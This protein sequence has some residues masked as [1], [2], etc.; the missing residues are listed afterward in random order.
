M[1]LVIFTD[2]DGTLLDHD[3]YDWRPAAPMIARLRDQG[4]PLVFVTSKTRAEVAVLRAEMGVDEP[5]IVENGAA[6]FFPERYGRLDLPEAVPIGAFRAL[7]FGRP[8]TEARDFAASVRG[9]FGLE[10]FGDMSVEEIAEVTGLPLEAAKRAKQREFTE[11]FRLEDDRELDRLAAAA[12]D[13]GFRITTGGRLHH[14]MGSDQDKGIA[15][16]AVRDA[17]GRALGAR[18][19]TVG[20]GDGPN[21]VPMLDAVD[22]AVLVPAP[23]RPL[24]EVRNDHVHVAPAPGPEGWA[25][26]LSKILGSVR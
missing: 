4:S 13:H 7:V 14:L 19:T 18:P 25:A 2:L 10:G 12:R 16:R 26:A 8:Y 20:L 11:P 5:F 17:F 21:D 22:E 3:T 1:R 6:A 9:R 24:P 23:G 15:V